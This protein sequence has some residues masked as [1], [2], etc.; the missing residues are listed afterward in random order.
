MFLTLL[1]GCAT[2]SNVCPEFPVPSEE[3]VDRLEELNDPAVNDWGN[4]LLRL[5]EKLEVCR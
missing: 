2:K 3:V 1:A 4:R 5:Q